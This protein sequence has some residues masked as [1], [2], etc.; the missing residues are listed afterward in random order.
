M[1]ITQHV[2]WLKK[3][4]PHPKVGNFWDWEN[5]CSLNTGTSFLIVDTAVLF[6]KLSILTPADKFCKQFGPTSKPF[7]S[8]PEFFL[9]WKVVFKKVRGWQLKQEKLTIM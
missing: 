9:F 5:D 4:W 1:N 6:T 8:F 2:C 3:L 7:D